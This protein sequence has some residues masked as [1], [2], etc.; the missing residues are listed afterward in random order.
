MLKSVLITG[1]SRGIGKAI[2]LRFAQEGFKLAITC[3]SNADLL[4]K[5][6]EEI[7]THNVPCVALVGDMGQY[8]T[9]QKLLKEAFNF[10]GGIDIIINNAGISYIGLLTDMSFAEWQNIINTNLSTLYYTCHFAIPDMIRNQKGKI[11]NISSIWGEVGASCEVAYSTT[12]GGMNAFTKALA[13]ELAPSNIQVNAI[14]CGA[15]DTDM[16]HFLSEED[17]AKL[18]EEIPSNRMGTPKEV[19][20]LAYFL[21]SKESNYLTGQVLRLD[22]GWI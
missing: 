8:E 14:A 13:K 11:I 21:A 9:A 15:I 1:A 5:V 22:G 4:H 16:N 10:L 20:N 19:A 2:A 12:K 7:E 6:K 18:I 17:K 3:K